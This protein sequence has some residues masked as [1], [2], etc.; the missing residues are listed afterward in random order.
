VAKVTIK[1]VA[2]AAGVSISTVSNAL[3]DVDVLKE[4]TKEHIL[5]VADDLNYM[6]NLRGKN[7]KAEKT[8]TLGF[9]TTNVNGPY[10]HVLVEALARQC[11]KMG[12]A[13]NIFVSQ[14]EEVLLNNLFGGPIDGAI[15][16]HY[17]FVDDKSMELMENQE[18]KTV[19]MDR[20]ITSENIGSILFDSYTT[21]YEATSYLINLGHKKIKFI[22]GHADTYDSINRKQGYI[23]AMEDNNLEVNSDAMLKGYFEEEGSYNAVKSYIRNKNNTTPDAFLAGNDLSAIGAIKALESEGFNIPDDISVMGF[24][25]IEIAQYYDPSLTTIRNPIARKGVLAVQQLVDLIDNDAEGKKYKLSGEI[26]ARESTSAR[27]D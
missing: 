18:I 14:D 15:V 12:Y 25:D 3:N 24:D 23:A 9:F 20:E 26:V 22:E 2:N 1:D 10:F 27:T 21:G 7:L 5:Q 8:N 11:E 17:D 13:L 19:F 4:K 6:P 16:Y